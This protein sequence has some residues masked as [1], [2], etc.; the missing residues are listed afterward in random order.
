MA[1]PTTVLYFQILHN[2]FSTELKIQTDSG[3]ARL[4][5]SIFFRLKAIQFKMELIFKMAILRVSSRSSEPCI[6]AIF[7]RTIFK[8]WILIKKYIRINVTFSIVDYNP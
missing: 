4:S 8:F 3:L 6:F 2:H 1:P 7:R 5:T